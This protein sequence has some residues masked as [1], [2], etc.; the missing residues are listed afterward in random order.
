[1]FSGHFRTFLFAVLTELYLS[2]L[3]T[4][5]NNSFLDPHLSL[6]DLPKLTCRR[7]F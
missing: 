4:L 1:M 2:T 7:N 6:R 5:L 3:R